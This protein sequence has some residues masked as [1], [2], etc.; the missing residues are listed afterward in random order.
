VLS[1]LRKNRFMIVLRDSG[2]SFQ[3]V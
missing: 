2:R 3:N 1:I